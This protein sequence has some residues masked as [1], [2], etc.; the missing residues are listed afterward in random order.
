MK[1]AQ[2]WLL[3]AVPFFISIRPFTPTLLDP[4]QATRTA[5]TR[6]RSRV[7]R[8]I[9]ILFR[10]RPNVNPPFT[11]RPLLASSSRGRR[12]IPSLCDSFPTHHL[13]VPGTGISPRGRES[14]TRQTRRGQLPSASASPSPSPSPDPNAG[15]SEVWVGVEDDVFFSSLDRAR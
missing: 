2:L 11:D 3:V 8:A 13:N 1:K 7:A 4:R 5:K 9:P 12:T 15:K 6:T 10:R 14:A